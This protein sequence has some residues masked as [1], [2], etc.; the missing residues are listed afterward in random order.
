[1]ISYLSWDNLLLTNF[2]KNTE[3]RHTFVFR[4]IKANAAFYLEV[5]NLQNSTIFV[6]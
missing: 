6:K 4:Q 1:M 3:L 2:S 5:E